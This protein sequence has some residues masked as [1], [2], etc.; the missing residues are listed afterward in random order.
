MGA[1]IAKEMGPVVSEGA[2]T[3]E[4]RAPAVRTARAAEVNPNYHPYA[5]GGGP[6]EYVGPMPYNKYDT[7]EASEGEGEEDT[8]EDD[9]AQDSSTEAPGDGGA[10]AWDEACEGLA[11]AA[12][13][14]TVWHAQIVPDSFSDARHCTANGSLKPRRPRPHVRAS[15]FL[16]AL[17][18]TSGGGWALSSEFGPLN[19]WPAL[20]ELELLSITCKVRSRL[21]FPRI[22]RVWDARSA[23]GER[24]G[25]LSQTRSV[26]ATLRAPPW[27]AVGWAA[28][29]AGFLWWAVQR[30]S[31]VPHVFLGE[32]A[33]T[34]I[35]EGVFYGSVD[36]DSRETHCTH[37]HV[38][39]HRYAKAL[40]NPKDKLTYHTVVLLEWSHGQCMTAVELAWRNG[41]SGYGGKSNFFDDRDCGQPVL[42][43]VTSPLPYALAAPSHTAAPLVGAPA[44]YENA[45]AE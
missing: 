16:G 5:H 41:V 12:G 19:G 13:G 9:N 14:G 31:G 45:V 35:R 39:A 40:E 27:T 24:P 33:P 15:E 7:D 6:H 44:K 43:Q 30:P 3:D 8:E 38:F 29:A 4:A 17:E 1:G 32:Q 42:Y 37:V 23:A 34:S 22:K 25:A 36:A 10:R 20:V 26:R 11:D 2:P 28:E 21:G 18:R